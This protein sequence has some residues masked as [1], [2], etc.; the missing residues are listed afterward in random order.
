M[1]VCPDD[2]RMKDISKV[3]E[4]DARIHQATVPFLAELSYEV[5]GM[6]NSKMLK[7]FVAFYLKTDQIKNGIH[8][9]CR[10]REV[11]TAKIL[12]RSLIEHTL[13]FLY[14]SFRY[15]R[16]GNDDAAVEYEL[17][18]E[19]SED[20]ETGKAWQEY[21]KLIRPDTPKKELWE[22]LRKV[23]S[24]FSKYT[25]KEVEEKVSQFRYKRIIR[26]A[27]SEMSKARKNLEHPVSRLILEYS[28]LSSFV[29]G[30]ALANNFFIWSRA[31]N[32]LNDEAYSVS[33]NA[34]AM[35]LLVKR[36]TFA[37]VRDL[38]DKY[39]VVVRSIDEL[40]VAHQMETFGEV[41]SD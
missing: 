16:E 23:N 30:G 31:E 9:L 10:E 19:L 6:E 3:F 33:D 13:R 7:T 40:S 28:E 15:V 20:M 5:A 11:Y 18:S 14:L 29:H 1:Y 12:Y 4:F 27:A 25:P 24:E 41:K 22:I 21:S 17:F 26:Y 8:G 35:A 36:G 32:E 34:I 39:D 38:D 2:E 37:A